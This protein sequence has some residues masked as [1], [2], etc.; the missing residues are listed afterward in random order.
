MLSMSSVDASDE[1]AG[2]LVRGSSMPRIIPRTDDCIDVAL[3]GAV[4]RMGPRVDQRLY[5]LR[6]G[7]RCLVHTGRLSPPVRRE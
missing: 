2:A 1:R 6:H 7:D 4:E 5:R 3:V